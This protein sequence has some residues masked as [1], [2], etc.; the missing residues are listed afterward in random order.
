MGTEIIHRRIK[1]NSDNE[2]PKEN[3]TIFNTVFETSLRILIILS[4]SNIALSTDKLVAVDFTT[5]YGKDFGISDFNLHGNS[6]FRYAE[7][8]ARI[9]TI[10]YAVKDLVTKGLIEPNCLLSGFKYSITP[11]GNKL[12]KALNSNYSK[13]YKKLCRRS[14]KFYE[15]KD[16]RQSFDILNNYAKT[17]TKAGI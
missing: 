3:T 4:V 5:I 12:V 17:F 1:Q 14:L 9:D 15:N 11:S 8:P 16:D 2:Y 10:G 7:I 6:Y 13:A